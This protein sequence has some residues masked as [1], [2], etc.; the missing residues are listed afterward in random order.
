MTDKGEGGTVVG[1]VTVDHLIAL[2]DEIVAMTRAGV[3]IEQGLLDLGADVPGRLGRVARALGERM[4]RGESLAVALASPAVGAPPVYRAVVEAGIRSGRLPVALEGLS[5]YARGYTEAR[6]SIGMALWYPLV[7][8]AMA[9]TLFLALVVTLIPRFVAAF[10]EMGLS[11]AAPLRWLDAAGRS[12]WYWGPVLPVG[13]AL[14]LGAWL[15]SR[16]GFG[17]GRSGA[18]WVLGW[19]PWMRSMMRGY[20]A[21]GFAD[22]LALLVENRVPYP[23]ALALAGEASGDPALSGSSRELAAAVARGLSPAESLRGRNAFPPLLRWLLAT[24]QGRDDLPSALRQTAARYRSGAR[25]QAETMRVFLPTLLLL[26]IG[27]TATVL[28]SLTLFVPLTS[29]WTSLSRIAP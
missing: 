3:P 16:R 27:G 8:L 6:R 21:A 25:H 5:A 15:G 7:V 13:L 2:N 18:P 28:Y 11:T 26:G 1:P 4:S 17:A 24:A 19:I 10:E 9:Y 23:E 20:E 29:L 14:C 22:L 12:A